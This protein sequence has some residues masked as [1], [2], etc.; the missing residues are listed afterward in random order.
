M[1]RP[2]CPKGEDSWCK[3]NKKDP[4][5]R[6]HGIP[7][8]VAD[9]MK[10][11][12]RDLAHPDVKKCLHGKT[13]NANEAFNHILWSRIPKTVFV[14]ANTLQIGLCD[15]VLSFNDGNVGRAKVLQKLNINPGFNT[16]NI[17]KELDEIRVKKADILME[18]MAKR[19]RRI[20]RNLKA[21]K[22]DTSDPGYGAGMF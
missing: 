18:Q 5:Y 16:V 1:T 7:P 6:H 11:V 20:Q 17:L 15:A 22:N 4:N 3:Y 21:T 12:Y 8:A 10:S 19:A 13:Q 2:L 9:V 14:G